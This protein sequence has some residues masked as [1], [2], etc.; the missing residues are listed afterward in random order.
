MRVPAGGETRPIPRP[1]RPHRDALR[2]RQGL[3]ALE[4]A[5]LAP[6]LLLFLAGLHD[7]TTAFIAWQRLTATAQATAQIATLMAATASSP[8]TLTVNQASAAA[9]VIYAYLPDTVTAATSRFGVTLSSVV[10]TPTVSTCTTACTYTAH[11][12]WSGVFAGAATTAR[13]CDGKTAAI[14][15]AADSAEPTA[16]TLPADAYS[17]APL[18]VV[19]VAYTF[20]PLFTSVITGSFQM[21]RAA[22]FAPRTGESSDWIRYFYAG[23][24]DATAHCTGY[25]WA[26]GS[27]T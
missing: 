11:V 3:A 17:A 2:C 13:P 26:T 14:S 7:L 12:A 4:F 21:R 9:S 24:P 1:S 23:S 27:A 8:N 25:G 6:V 18:L 22:Y 20:T 10:M 5:F 15:V 19:D 16:S